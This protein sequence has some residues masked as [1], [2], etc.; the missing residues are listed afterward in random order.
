[1]TVKRSWAEGR[2]RG[3]LPQAGQ[4]GRPC[5]TAYYWD[6]KDRER[7]A[8]TFPNKKDADRA[9]QRAEAKVAEGR[10]GDPGRGRQTFRAYVEQ[11][12]LAPGP[13]DLG[14]RQRAA[15]LSAVPRLGVDAQAATDRGQAVGHALQAV[16]TGRCR[17][18]R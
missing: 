2:R 16:G 11:V 10:L 8:G 12:W 18:P 15:H 9:W 13:G 17:P 4:D 7:S 6:D 14:Y 1:M 5:Y 3:V